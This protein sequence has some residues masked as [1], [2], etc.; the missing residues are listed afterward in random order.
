MA[1]L[2]R[3]GRQA[4]DVPPISRQKRTFHLFVPAG[5]PMLA[6][7]RASARHQSPP[8]RLGG[9]VTLIHRL[10][11]NQERSP[12]PHVFEVLRTEKSLL[13]KLL[14]LWYAVSLPFGRFVITLSTGL[15]QISTCLLPSQVQMWLTI[16]ASDTASVVSVCQ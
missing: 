2:F 16:I 5:C 14:S 3:A 7:R 13:C 1:R 15:T 6:S 9:P 12:T 4:A 10:W 8:T 11:R